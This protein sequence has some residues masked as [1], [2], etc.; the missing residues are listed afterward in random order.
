MWG[1]WGVEPRSPGRREWHHHDRARVS[2]PV[3]PHGRPAV[4]GEETKSGGGHRGTGT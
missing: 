2:W 3:P 1:V 4:H